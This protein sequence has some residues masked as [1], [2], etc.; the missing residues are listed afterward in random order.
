[1]PCKSLSETAWGFGSG[2]RSTRLSEK[3]KASIPPNVHQRGFTADKHN[4]VPNEERRIAR[5]TMR[6]SRSLG[7]TTKEVLRLADRVLPRQ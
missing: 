5:R 6:P 3:W 4:G 2:H 7:E 1:M